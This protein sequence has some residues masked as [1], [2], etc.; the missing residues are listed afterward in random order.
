MQ[1]GGGYAGCVELAGELCAACLV[2]VKTSARPLPLVEPVTT[3]ARSAGWTVSRWWMIAAGASAG[4]RLCS[5][6]WS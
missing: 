5:A 6:G 4:P 2:R 1:L 3:A